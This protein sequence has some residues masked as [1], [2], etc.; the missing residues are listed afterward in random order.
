MQ[1]R[2][3]WSKLGKLRFTSHRDMARIWERALRQAQVPVTYTQ[4]FSPRAKLAFGLA[5]PTTFESMSE[6]IDVSLN[7]VDVDV[8]AI[9][10]GV[11][12][13]L[14]VGVEVTAAVPLERG[15]TSLQ[16]AVTSSTWLLAVAA[17]ESAV[18]TWI[19]GVLAATEIVVTRERKGKAVTDDLR[20]AILSLEIAEPSLFDAASGVPSESVCIVADLATQPRALRPGELLD[21]FEP[22]FTFVRGRRLHQWIAS[23]GARREPISL[24]AAA[25]PHRESVCV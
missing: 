15:E 16:Q 12:P 13:F 10:H 22:G 17:E 23:A 14:P 1:A 20:P 19:D 9:A 21:I 6:Y 4:G 18:S 7:T 2:L 3:R 5:L 11:T 8:S 24:G 25:T